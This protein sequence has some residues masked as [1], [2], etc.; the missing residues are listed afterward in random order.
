MSLLIFLL[1]ANHHYQINFSTTNS[2]DTLF[3]V[4]KYYTTNDSCSK[5]FSTKRAILKST[6]KVVR[7]R[8]LI[9]YGSQVHHS[10]AN[11]GC[12]TSLSPCRSIE[13]VRAKASQT[14]VWEHGEINK[15]TK[16]K[17]RFVE[18]ATA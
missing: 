14:D 18:I 3:L 11:G 1:Y 2:V 17:R 4:K 9:T 10:I 7:A 16:M 5:Y 15:F 8:Y 6:R 12:T 13:N